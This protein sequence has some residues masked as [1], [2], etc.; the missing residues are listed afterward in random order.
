MLEPDK[1]T[2]I[3]DVLRR[4]GKLLGNLYMW[5]AFYAFQGIAIKYITNREV[6]GELWS[7][8]L[9]R[10]LWGHYHM[11]FVFLML[12]FYLLLPITRKLCESKQVIEYYLIL[13]VLT[14]YIIPVAVSALKLEWINT[15]IY[16]LSMNML[17]GYLGYFLLGFYLKK[18][19][20]SRRVRRLLYFA[21]SVGLLYTI[22]GTIV[23]S[24][25][26]GMCCDTLFSPGSWNILLF[27]AAVYVFFVNQD[28][29]SFGYPAVRKI[30]RRSFVIYMVHPFF[31]EKLNMIG[32]TTVSFCS[33][34]SVPLLT[35]LIFL[36]SDI[37]AAVITGIPYLKKLIV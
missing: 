14:A 23:L 22:I 28:G 2:S 33:L 1:E 36:C 21:G 20:C 4:F 30:A 11:W 19:P 31:L 7:E 24:N 34:F 13:W 17:A 6:T 18:Y 8:A 3:R 32:I 27:A 5:S 25:I 26:Q 29:L 35:L 12:G 9:Q 37:V 15:W 16:K 10:F